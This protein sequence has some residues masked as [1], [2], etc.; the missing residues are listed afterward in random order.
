[1]PRL[2]QD[3]PPRSG[4]TQARDTAAEFRRELGF[5]EQQL[6]PPEHFRHRADFASV[7][8]Q[9]RGELAQQPV[10]LAQL[11]FVN[12]D[13]LVIQVDRLQRLDEHGVAAAA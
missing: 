4:G 8:A 5:G 12:P 2:A 13:Q 10:N 3:Q 1:M 6:Q 11:L 9:P 7:L